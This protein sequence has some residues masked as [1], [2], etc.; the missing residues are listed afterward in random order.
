MMD[1]WC[2]TLQVHSPLTSQPLLTCHPG[3]VKG[4]KGDFIF[5]TPH[6]IEFALNIFLALR[7][8]RKVA[9][10]LVIGVPNT[11]IQ[12]TKDFKVA[13]FDRIDHTLRGGKKGLIGFEVSPYVP[14]TDMS[15]M[16]D[17]GGTRV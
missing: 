6:V 17:A 11:D 15:L 13:C 16:H 8:T 1:L 7:R 3:E 5:D 12:L 10:L 2:C 4:D 14:R 9:R